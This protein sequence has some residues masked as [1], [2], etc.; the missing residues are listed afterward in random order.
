M[1]EQPVIRIAA[2]VVLN[3]AGHLL[4]VRKR[5]TVVFMQPGGKLELGETGEEAL[6]RELREELGF[7]L[8]ADDLDYVGRFEAD[9]ANEPGHRVDCDVH[10]TVIETDGVVAAEIEE[11]IWVDP[12][13]MSHLALAPLT[14][15]VM[16]PYILT[17]SAAIQGREQA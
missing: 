15:H 4:L 12:F 9:A 3:P 5:D 8:T 13:E 17:M 14:E 16:L 11:R 10:F 1:P 2:A 6:L 7:D